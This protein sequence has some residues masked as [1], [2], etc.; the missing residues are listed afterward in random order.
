MAYTSIVVGTDGSA[1]L[2]TLINT[3]YTA[4]GG[5]I[6]IDGPLKCGEVKIKS[7]ITIQGAAR[8]SWTRASAWG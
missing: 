4:G 7:G 8:G 2:Q 3:V 5:T 1:A 6:I